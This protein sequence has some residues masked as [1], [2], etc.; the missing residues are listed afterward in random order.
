[1]QT[2]DALL[3]EAIAN[4]FANQQA[5]SAQYPNAFIVLCGT[6]TWGPYVTSQEAYRVA[7]AHLEPGAFLV[8]YCRGSTEV[9]LIQTPQ[10]YDVVASRIEDLLDAFPGSAKAMELRRLTKVVEFASR[11][12]PL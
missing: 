9:N 12:L 7:V 1:M 5:L 11:G 10:E 6:Q 2:P 3:N 8:K 4:Y